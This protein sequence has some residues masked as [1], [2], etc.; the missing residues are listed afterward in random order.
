MSDSQP[1]ATPASPPVPGVITALSILLF[2]GAATLVLAV[3]RFDWRSLGGALSG[4]EYV[5][6]AA[7]YVVLGLKLRQRRRWARLVLVV[8]CVLSGLLAVVTLVA[9]GAEA[10][11]GRLIWPVIYLALLATPQ[12][13]EWFRPP[14]DPA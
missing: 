6:F 9:G 10:G 5:V 2:V 1:P 13:R 7:L 4:L 12:A 11:L 3:P 14:P 8:L